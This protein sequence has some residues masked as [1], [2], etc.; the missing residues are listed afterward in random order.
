MCPSSCIPLPS[1][2]EYWTNE[3]IFMSLFNFKRGKPLPENVTSDVN[4][5]QYRPSDLPA[6]L[7]Y[8]WSG[9]QKDAE[10]G[11]WQETEEPRET[12]SNSIIV[13]IKTTLQFYEGRPSHSRKT[14]WL[15]QRYT[16]TEKCDKDTKDPR[17]LCRVFLANTDGKISINLEPQ[18]VSLSELVGRPPHPVFEQSSE[19]DCILRRDYLELNDLI[20]PGS[21]TS[22]S[23]STNSSCLTMTSDEYFDSVAL[24]QEIENDTKGSS[25]RFNLSAPL[26]STEVFIHPATSVSLITDQDS[27][28]S[29]HETTKDCKSL[30]SSKSTSKE[31][32][33]QRVSKTKTRKMMKYLCFR[34]F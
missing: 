16:I 25:V 33:K 3:V 29:G 26:K 30:S 31:G 32:K 18:A 7:W 17:A 9:V 10:C 11:F 14:D 12:F 8:L 21:R 24:L 15:M 19:M 28:S 27:K 5:Y 23:V 1:K 13:G 34:P 4:P 22:S 6:D 2:D 20:D